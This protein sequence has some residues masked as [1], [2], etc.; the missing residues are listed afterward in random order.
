MRT[1]AGLGTVW[2]LF[3][4]TALQQNSGGLEESR[5][6]LNYFPRVF[7]EMP[8]RMGVPFPQPWLQTG[9]GRHGIAGQGGCWVSAAGTA[10]LPSQCPRPQ[11]ASLRHP[12]PCEYSLAVNTCSCEPTCCSPWGTN[13]SRPAKPSSSPHPSKSCY[14]PE[15]PPAHHVCQCFATTQPFTCSTF[16]PGY[17]IALD[18]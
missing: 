14:L 11:S 13:P 12:E 16:R 6:P 4:A 10:A 9:I 5:L 8:L 3:A 18:S 2:Q 7:P 17:C 1:A 15:F